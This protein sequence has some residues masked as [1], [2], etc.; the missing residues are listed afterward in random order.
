[1][2]NQASTHWKVK[3][4]FP[5]CVCLTK[6]GQLDDVSCQW[7]F[8]RFDSSIKLLEPLSKVRY[9]SFLQF[10]STFPKH[11]NNRRRC[12]QTLRRLQY[13]LNKWRLTALLF[14]NIHFL[15]DILTDFHKNDFNL[16]IHVMSKNLLQVPWPKLVVEA[17]GGGASGRA[18]AC[19]PNVGEDLGSNPLGAFSLFLPSVMWV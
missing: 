1:M 5:C 6:L 14:G 7:M 19:R 15:K 18:A 4:G 17:S 2:F 10:Y 13:N 12:G 9:A 11:L 3:L 8:N 16:Q